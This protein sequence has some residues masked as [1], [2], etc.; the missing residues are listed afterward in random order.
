MKRK[1]LFGALFL[2]FVWAADSCT[3]LKDCKFCKN[4]T[5]ENGSVVSSG[6]ETEYCGTDL[7]T[8]EAKPDVTVGSLTTKVECR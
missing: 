4:V 7:I 3:A 2:F 8:Q 5:Y 1:L 6:T